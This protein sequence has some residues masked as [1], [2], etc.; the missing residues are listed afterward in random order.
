MRIGRRSDAGARTA[1]LATALVA[2]AHAAG[3][4]AAQK[5]TPELAGEPIG[6]DFAIAEECG[7][8]D[9]C[10]DYFRAF[11]DHLLVVEYTDDG[12]AAACAALG[13]G[14]SI[15]LRDLYLV[16]PDDPDH[17]YATCRSA[18]AATP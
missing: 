14:V 9:E 3:L 15:I 6:F 10:E 16:P 13:D 12:L 7:V 1:E 4:A 5:N 17:R 11:G 8:Y 18:L 2:A